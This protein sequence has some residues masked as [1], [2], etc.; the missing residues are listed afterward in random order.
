MGQAVTGR[1]WSTRSLLAITRSLLAIPFLASIACGQ[2]FGFPGPQGGDGW[3]AQGGTPGFGFPGPQGETASAPA[4][5]PS[6]LADIVERH[7]AND[8]T[9]LEHSGAVLNGT[10]QYFK[11]AADVTG[12]AYPWSASIWARAD[13]GQP[14]APDVLL[15]FGD[16]ATTDEIW[17]IYVDTDGTLNFNS[18]DG[19]SASIAT[20][21]NTLANGATGWFHVFVVASSATDREIYLNGSAANSGTNTTS[22]T[23]TGLDN[24]VVGARHDGSGVGRYFD[25]GVGRIDLW[26]SAPTSGSPRDTVAA[27][28]AAGYDAATGFGSSPQNTW[29]DQ[30]TD[31]TDSASSADLTANNTPTTHAECYVWRDTIGTRHWLAASTGA[32]DY[33]ANWASSGYPAIVFDDSATEAMVY[34]GAPFV[35]ASPFGVWV[36][37]GSD[38][39]TVNQVVWEVHDTTGSFDIFRNVLQMAASNQWRGVW[40]G[41]GAATTLDTTTGATVNTVV[42]GTFFSAST[43]SFTV[44]LDGAGDATSTTADTPA[45]L[46][47]MDVGRAYVA[48]S[49]AA[50]LSGAILEWIGTSDDPTTDEEADVE[51]Y[52]T[53]TYGTP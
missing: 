14:A 33:T 4:F 3:G 22:S 25:G 38:D 31:G 18:R 12:A 44:R 45:G 13:D 26:V 53:S 6:Q 37:C 46:N 49:P 35:T 8:A 24:T 40:N 19:G 2:G 20:T 16:E 51:G 9:T 1:R 11:R 34:E 52:S 5:D 10:N 21:A 23:P 42:L 29:F 28:L 17:S 27:N 47:R 50:Y 32:P 43:T 30:S 48:G 39:D 15:S 36:V 41:A 7:V